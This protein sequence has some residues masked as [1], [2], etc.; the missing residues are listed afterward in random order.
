MRT[1]IGR[2]MAAIMTRPTARLDHRLQFEIGDFA[3]PFD[4]ALVDLGFR[5]R[6]RPEPPA[7]GAAIGPTV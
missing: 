7:A 5:G 3:R 2:Y 4:F 6:H 1:P